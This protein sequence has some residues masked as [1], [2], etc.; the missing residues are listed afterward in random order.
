MP[1]RKIPK[2]YLLVTGGYSSSKNKEMKG[3]E[4]L[5]EKEYLLL[6]DFDDSVESF[7]VQ[8]VRIPVSGVPKGYVPDVLVKYRPDPQT[9][10]TRKPSLIEVK[11]SNDLERNADKYAPKFAAARQYAEARDW[12]FITIDQH[13]IRTPRLA[14]IKFLREFRNVA[15][16]DDDIQAVLSAATASTDDL[17]LQALLET[18]ASTDDDKLYWMPIIWSMVVSRHLG[19]NLN[20][21]FDNDVE[22]WPYGGRT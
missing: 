17:T 21:R 2:N 8:P 1:V 11:H 13:Q 3:F 9:N 16:S 15:P 10:K 22:L 7:D 18:L 12:E 19:T 6:L 14:N 20:K 4:S 5:L